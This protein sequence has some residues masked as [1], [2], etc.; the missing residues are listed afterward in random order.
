MLVT[1]ATDLSLRAIICCSVVFGV[2]LKL[3]VTIS[4]SSPAINKL[5]RKVGTLAVDGWDVTFGTARRGLGGIVLLYYDGSLLCGF[6]VA[7][8]GLNAS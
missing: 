7:I 6:N 5:C 3:L 4:S 1:H 8:K 2:T